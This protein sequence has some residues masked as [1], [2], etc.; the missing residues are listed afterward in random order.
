MGD[1]ADWIDEQ[2]ED[3]LIAHQ[4]GYCLE[5]CRYCWECVDD[6]ENI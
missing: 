2:G 1:I 3:E 6:E 4:S 5:D